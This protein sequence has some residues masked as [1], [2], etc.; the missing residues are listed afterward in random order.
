MK[1]LLS[2]LLTGVL[3]C[4]VLA[5]PVYPGTAPGQAAVTETA[6]DAQTA[7]KISNALLSA[8]YLHDTRTGRLTFGGLS[9]QGKNVAAPENTLFIINVKNGDALRSENMTLQ[10]VSAGNDP[11]R[12]DAVKAADRLPSCY[13]EAVFV[14]DAVTVRWRAVLH[15]GSHYLRTEM[16]ISS[17]EVLE[18]NSVI[19]M[20]YPVLPN[21]GAVVVRGTAKSGNPVTS[22]DVFCGLETPTGVNTVTLPSGS[23]AEWNPFAW[24]PNSWAEVADPSSI[25]E[26]MTTLN[27]TKPGADKLVTYGGR[28]SY[29]A[30]G[31]DTVMFR[32]ASGS[33][34]LNIVGVQ[35]LSEE[36]NVVSQDIHAGYTGTAASKNSY[37]L[38]VPSAGTYRLRYWVETLTETITSSGAITHTLAPVAVEEDASNDPWLV[39]GRWPRSAALDPE[40]S[41]TL[42]VW[43]I[44]SVIGVLAPGQERRSLL[45]YTERQRAVPYRSMVHYNSWYE[46]NINRNGGSWQQRMQ[47]SQC[48]D[49]VEAWRKNLFEAHQVSLDA[50]VWD[51]GWDDFDSLW[52]FHP[53][54]PDGFSNLNT[55][56]LKQGAGQGAWLGP[57]GGYAPAQGQRLK[58]WSSQHP[59]APAFN[60]SNSV[61]FKGF[62]DRCKFMVRNYDMR[63]F[64]FD[65]IGSDAEGI[66]NVIRELRTEREDLYFNCTVG[67]WASP[68]WFLYADSTWRDGNDYQERGDGENDGYG[69]RNKWLTYRDDQIYTTFVT[70]S[71]LCTLNSLMFHG[72]IHSSHGGPNAMSKDLESVKWEMRFSVACG[73]SLQELYVDKDL[74]TPEHWAELA[75]C[76]NWFRKNQDVLVD[77]HWVGGDPWDASQ[78]EDNRGGIYG[79]ASWNRDKATLALRNSSKA[80]H[81][82]SFT[83]RQALDIPAGNN[84]SV[85]LRAVYADQ[86]EH[87]ELTEKALSPDTLV[88]VTMQPYE[89]IVFD[90]GENEISARTA[91]DAW[92]A[93]NLGGADAENEDLTSETADPDGDGIVNLMEFALGGDMTKPDRLNGREGDKALIIH[94]MEAENVLTMTFTPNPDAADVVK[95]TAQFSDDLQ[96]WE[97]VPVEL[98]AEAFRTPTPV[99][100]KDPR[101]TAFSSRRFARL[102]VEMKTGEGQ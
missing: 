55:E 92:I 65:G 86:P 89:I 36:G 35:L 41:E 24:K 99:T 45:V 56:C 6:A 85:A 93:S 19:A 98:P 28:V 17:T 47:E 43:E 12:K 50:F 29:A 88:T 44:S 61:Y 69:H 83:L 1:T 102:K 52:N 49:V 53:G 30:A 13:V 54:F 21:G 18:A 101:G 5:V 16:K 77:V 31:T 70:K 90:T 27:G 26:D 25:P 46:L 73:S 9:V 40:A 68:F 63:Y 20:R 10:S 14:K 78:A 81:S 23:G 48:M 39:Q 15:D 94:G 7:Y 97:D 33:H 66:I 4:H 64:K 75:R 58:A 76:I 74:M 82:Y 38:Q 59:E 79:W 22:P 2:L 51:D 80:P 72:L 42:R 95:F 57:T 91:C 34:R 67:T 87:P 71:P 96:Q 60:L 8:T 62:T 32:Y 37:V 100:V 84:D 11:G 3:A